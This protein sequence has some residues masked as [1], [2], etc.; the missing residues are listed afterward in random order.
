MDGGAT[1]AVDVGCGLLSAARYV[2]SPNQDARPP[3]A[4]LD[5]VVVHGISLPPG[6]FGGDWVERLFTNRLPPDGHEYFAAIAGLRVSAHLFVR[7]DGEL[8][9]FVPFHARAWHAGAS[10]WRHRVACNDYSVGIELEGEDATPYSDRQYHVLAAV[11]AAL[12]RTYA[13]LR[14]DAADGRLAGH[15]EIAPGRKTD[16]GPAFDWSRLHALL[17]AA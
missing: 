12:R 14:P 17:A 1:L 6:R 2:P 9:Q 8:V 11:I 7:R 5:L 10:V 3:G 4:G 13:T 15:S 16:P